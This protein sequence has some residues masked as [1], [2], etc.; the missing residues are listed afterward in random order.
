MAEHD[1]AC[2]WC[3]SATTMENN[4]RQ[5]GDNHVIAAS[6]WWRECTRLDCRSTGPKMRSQEAA[7]L[8]YLKTHQFAE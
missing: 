7:N 4:R 2:P 3:G 8:A 5:I 6:R 1:T